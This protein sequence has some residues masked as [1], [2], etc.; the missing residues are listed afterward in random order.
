MDRDIKLVKLEHIVSN[1]YKTRINIDDKKLR[2][3]VTSIKH[4]GIVQPLVLR[5]LS[6]KFEIISGERRFR[7]AKLAGMV[8]VP[9]ILIHLNDEMSYEIASITNLHD[10]SFNSIEEGKIYKQLLKKYSTFEVMDRLEKDETYIMG[11]VA[12]LDLHQEVQE[13]L[14]YNKISE[15]HAKT[16]LKVN[17][18]DQQK[19][20]LTEI[21]EKKL[22]VSQLIK[23]LQKLNAESNKNFS[24]NIKTA[25]NTINDTIS[26]L[27]RFGFKVTKNE[28]DLDDKYTV[29]INIKK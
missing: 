26:T 15:G 10:T 3:L 1:R 27:E 20:L 9:A 18:K 19:K 7:A 29:T 14:L 13:A 4:Y 25:V 17:K 22:T 2:E 16:L 5:K 8:A 23:R 11:K 24:N 6:G 21:L 28:L 12:L